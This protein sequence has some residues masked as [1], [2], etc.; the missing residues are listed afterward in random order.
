M[1]TF[2]RIVRAIQRERVAAGPD[3]SVD[4][5]IKRLLVLHG[6]LAA[7]QVSKLSEALQF[8]ETTRALSIAQE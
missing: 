8:A 5:A 4:L 7:T 3:A 2:L 6:G 1:T